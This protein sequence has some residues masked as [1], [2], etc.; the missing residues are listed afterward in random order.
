MK[1][2]ENNTSVKF[3][4][5]SLIFFGSGILS[6]IIGYILLSSGDIHFAPLFLVLGYVVFI[7]LAILKK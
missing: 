6:G 3:S 5:K 4:K 7:P 2:P 1:N